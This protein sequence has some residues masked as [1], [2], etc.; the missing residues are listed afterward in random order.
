MKR[1]ASCASKTKAEYFLLFYLLTSSVIAV[2]V[3]VLPVGCMHRKLVL[4]F[5]T[6]YRRPPPPSTEGPPLAEELA[7]KSLKPTVG[8]GRDEDLER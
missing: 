7:D 1:L 4:T 5:P 6:R 2:L 8:L 3:V